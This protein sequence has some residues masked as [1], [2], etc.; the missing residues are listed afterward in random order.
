MKKLKVITLGGTIAMKEDEHGK[1][2]PALSGENLV[3]CVPGL[4]DVAEISIEPFC[5]IPSSHLTIDLIFGVA[6]RIKE[7]INTQEADGVVVIQGTDTLEETA[8]LLDLVL[9]VNNPV[10]L[11]GAM[12]NASEASYDGTL[13][14]LNACRVAADEHAYNKGVMLLG[15]DL[16]LPAREVTKTHTSD[17]ATFQ[18]P[19][20]GPLGVVDK[21][22]VIF[23]RAPLIRE[24]Y[25][26][27][28]SN[29]DVVLVKMAVDT[30]PHLIEHCVKQKVDGIVIE[31]FGRGHVPPAVIP[32]I[33]KAIKLGIPVVL[34]SRCGQGL[35][36]DAYGHEASASHLK[37]LGIIFGGDLIG[38][39]ARI[40]LI[41]L[42]GITKDYEMIRE[43]FE[44]DL[45]SI[46]QQIV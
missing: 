30:R 9:G 31:G 40:K 1:A 34:T 21:H 41:T 3:A 20:G 46:P 26:V 27:T 35:V 11:V 5:N 13:N 25:A 42:L 39:K 33:E 32:G 4:K 45:Y 19:N 16:I 37:G 10:V 24:H 36:L 17:V 44:S 28:K 43:A 23:Y 7:I 38:Q 12:R 22:K 18:A 2:S 8:Y 14:I 15:N 6:N 29:A